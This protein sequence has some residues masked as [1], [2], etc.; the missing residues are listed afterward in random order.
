MRS[1][2]CTPKR[3]TFGRSNRSRDKHSNILAARLRQTRLRTGS[4]IKYACSGLDC[5]GACLNWVNASK[6]GS[7]RWLSSTVEPLA[8]RYRRLSTALDFSVWT[9][10]KGEAA[11]A[12]TLGSAIFVSAA[13]PVVALA[14]AGASTHFDALSF[15]MAGSTDRAVQV[16]LGFATAIGAIYALVLAAIV[17]MLQFHRDDDGGFMVIYLLRESWTHW[18]LG[19]LAGLIIMNL[20]GPA[21]LT[22]GLPLSFAPLLMTNGLLVPVAFGWSLWLLSSTIRHSGRRPFDSALDSFRLH[23]MYAATMDEHITALQERFKNRLEPGGLTLQPWAAFPND[24]DAAPAIE[25][26]LPPNRNVV[27]I[28]LRALLELEMLVDEFLADWRVYLTLGP[29]D[30][31][32]SHPGL[33][34]KRYE[35]QREV[36]GGRRADQLGSIGDGGDAV[37]L[38]PDVRRRVQR[39]FRRTFRLGVQSMGANDLNIFYERLGE[40]LA[41]AAKDGED[42]RLRQ[43]LDKLRTIAHDWSRLSQKGD[44]GTAPPWFRSSPQSFAG[45]LGFDPREVV[46]KAVQSGDPDTVHAVV[47]FLAGCFADSLRLRNVAMAHATGTLLC[48]SYARSIKKPS[49]AKRVASDLDGMLWTFATMLKSL[50]H[51]MRS[52]AQAVAAYREERPVVE[53]YLQVALQAIKTAMER[54]RTRD[55]VHFVERLYEPHD[56]AG[57]HPQPEA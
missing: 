18:G 37:E 5:R 21:L 41:R 39:A 7:A 38:D 3:N 42:L 25:F 44:P 35:A 11:R 10:W 45:P 9:R 13:V 57:R 43:I 40:Q 23:V 1:F 16:C 55:A 2:V 14:V 20:I 56:R 15:S 53:Q 28:N 27:D 52:P 33:V 12:Q 24:W 22:L 6:D 47:M 30:T 32:T 8:D 29:G 50:P 19:L 4:L 17:F 26:E 31:T 54:G 46:T 36:G 49:L 34:L 51:S 48:I